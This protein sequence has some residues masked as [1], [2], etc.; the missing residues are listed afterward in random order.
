MVANTW[1][2]LKT[3][4]KV[5]KGEGVGRGA[6]GGMGYSGVMTLQACSLLTRMTRPHGHVSHMDHC[7]G[8]TQILR[9]AE[10]GAGSRFAKLANPW[11]IWQLMQMKSVILRRETRPDK[12]L[13]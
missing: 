3:P 13:V 1:A 5:S 10:P 4:F 12:L 2:S 6:L 8:M 9:L 7:T 11:H